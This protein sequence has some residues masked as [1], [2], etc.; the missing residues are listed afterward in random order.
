M[1]KYI[2]VLVLGITAPLFSSNAELISHA[3]EA[4]ERAYAPYSNYF[5]GAALLTADGNIIQGCNVENASY[6]M[7]C[8]AER[9]AIFSAVSQGEREFAA[10]V[11]ATKDGG[12]PCGGCRQVLNEFN[13]EMRVI[14]VN[15]A[16]QIVRATTLN[17]LLPD[18]FGPKN[19]D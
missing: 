11:V 14:M 1:L 10:I 19:L 6:G 5:V 15:A 16:G 3:L 2:F 7:T 13:P 9:S 17:R 18:A 12:S 8:C 4:R